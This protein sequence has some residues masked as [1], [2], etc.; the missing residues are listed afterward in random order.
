MI[1][2]CIAPIRT[3]GARILHRVQNL[4]PCR[5][6]DSAYHEEKDLGR[7][8]SRRGYPRLRPTIVANAQMGSI[9]GATSNFTIPNHPRCQL[10]GSGDGL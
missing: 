10:R 9:R 7:V 1:P 6:G 4:P 8:T 5:R 2:A 3:G